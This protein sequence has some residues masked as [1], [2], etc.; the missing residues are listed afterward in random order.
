[1]FQLVATNRRRRRLFGPGVGRL[2]PVLAVLLALTGGAVARAEGRG[3]TVHWEPAQPEEGTAFIVRVDVTGLGDGAGAVTVSGKAAGEALHFTAAG[4]GTY[5]A[6]AAAPLD[7][8]GSLALEVRAA[9]SS[10]SIGAVQETVPI[11]TGVYSLER[12]TVAPQFVQTDAET[13]AR[14]ARDRERAA[15]VSRRAQETP[16]LWDRIVA[17]RDSRITSPFGTGREFNGQVQSRHSGVDFAGAVGAPVH[18]AA[19]GIVAVVDSF[20]LAGNVVYMNHGGGL[21]TG[22]FHLSEALVEEGQQVAAGD[23]IARVGATGRVTGPHLH[24]QVRYGH[25]NI[26]GLK[27]L[28]LLESL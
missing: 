21:V 27:L 15:E 7:R 11:R 10:G 12:L 22:Y 23:L 3:M 13:A 4:D 20:H 26:D 16:R 14:Q 25:I 8:G 24:W 19:D 28:E 1:M 2:L 9:T 17:P 18:A 6:L 5:W